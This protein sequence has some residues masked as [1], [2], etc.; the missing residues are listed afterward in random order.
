[1]GLQYG[2]Q[3]VTSGYADT[4]CFGYKAGDDGPLAIDEPDAKVVR[5][6]FELRAGG[7]NLGKIS[8]WLYEQQVLSPTGKER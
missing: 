7:A 4:I 3:Q 8:N 1:M 2:F 6:M 5:Q